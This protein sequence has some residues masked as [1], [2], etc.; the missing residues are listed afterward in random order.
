MA[1]DRD[2]VRRQFDDVVNITPKEL[3]DWLGT[4][5]SR[6]VDWKGGGDESVGQSQAGIVAIKPNKKDQLTDDDIEH[7]RYDWS[8]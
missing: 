3:E 6:A 5:E 1:S 7:K 4:D 8:R 2:D